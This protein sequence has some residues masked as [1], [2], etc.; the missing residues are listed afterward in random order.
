MSKPTFKSKRKCGSRSR[1]VGTGYGTVPKYFIK[2]LDK[3]QRILYPEIYLSNSDNNEKN[4]ENA[5]S[6]YR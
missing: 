6:G 1:Y 3:N 2:E 4:L 5:G